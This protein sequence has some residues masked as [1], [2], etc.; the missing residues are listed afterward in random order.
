[1]PLVLEKYKG[2]TLPEGTSSSEG[3]I[4]TRIHKWIT[5]TSSRPS[6]LATTSDAEQYFKVYERYARNTAN[7]AVARATRAGEVLP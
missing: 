6:V 3:K 5:A 4:W 1:M 2:F 7:S